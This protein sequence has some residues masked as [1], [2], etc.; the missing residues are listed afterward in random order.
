MSEVIAKVSLTEGMRFVG[1]SNSGHDVV[2]DGPKEHGGT[3]SAA[4]PMELILIGLGGCTAMD[5]VSIL[6]KKKQPV[7]GLELFITGTRAE[8][9]PMRYTEVE[10]EFVARGKGVDEAAV[11]RAVEL[12]MEKYC[13]VKATLELETKV[14]YSYRVEAESSENG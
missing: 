4:R 1:S 2:M 5:A 9:H 3:D 14:N 6:R 13:S 7:E 10:I 8:K 11:K 12:S